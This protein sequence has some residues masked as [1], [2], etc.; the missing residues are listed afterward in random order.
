AIQANADGPGSDGDLRRHQGLFG[1]CA[2]GA[3]AGIP[4][5]VSPV[6]PDTQC[7]AREVDRAEEGVERRPREAI[8]G[9]PY[10]LQSKDLAEVN[11]LAALLDF[12]ELSRAAGHVQYP[13]DC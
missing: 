9:C 2:G 4:E 3:G 13:Y 5:C 11:H 10:R 7:S 6:R 1:R 8:E 12:G